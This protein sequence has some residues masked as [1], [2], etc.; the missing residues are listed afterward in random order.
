MAPLEDSTKTGDFMK[1][2]YKQFDSITDEE[3]RSRC[4]K[5]VTTV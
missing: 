2:F 1:D 5:V 4:I 3:E